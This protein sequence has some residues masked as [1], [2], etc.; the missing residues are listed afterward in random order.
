MSHGTEDDIADLMRNPRYDLPRSAATSEGGAGENNESPGGSDDAQIREMETLLAEIGQDVSEL[1]VSCWQFSRLD[2]EF[3]LNFL[4][5]L[6]RNDHF[7][8]RI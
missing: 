7:T 3:N 5:P 2:S 8:R 6:F 4:P 1:K